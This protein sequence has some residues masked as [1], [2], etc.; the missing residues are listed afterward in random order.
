MRYH[1]IT[2]HFEDGDRL[3]QLR[4]VAVEGGTKVKA[5]YRCRFEQD[6]HVVVERLC[7]TADVKRA[8]D[9]LRSRVKLEQL[10]QTLELRAVSALD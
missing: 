7:G 2:E 5:S 9:S 10:R 4:A 6:E 3:Y 1:S 8:L